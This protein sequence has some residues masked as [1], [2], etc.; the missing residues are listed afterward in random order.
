MSVNLC[1]FPSWCRFFFDVLWK[2]M[3]FS[4][5]WFPH[6]FIINFNLVPKTFF[7]HVV[8][9]R[10]KKW[11]KMK[12]YLSSTK[13]RAAQR[14]VTQFI[15]LPVVCDKFIELII[16]N[17]QFFTYTQLFCVNCEGKFATFLYFYFCIEQKN[18][19]KLFLQQNL[20]SPPKIEL[21]IKIHGSFTNVKSHKN[22]FRNR[23]NVHKL[24][25]FRKK[26]SHKLYV[27][28]KWFSSFLL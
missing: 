15:I 17:V 28:L 23:K 9:V 1:D 22:I 20:V 21:N 2:L 14:W 27:P 16:E 8:W 11:E 3:N 19:R 5:S 26:F 18:M 4:W 12:F 13:N 6:I 24:S 7:Y 25:P 10:S